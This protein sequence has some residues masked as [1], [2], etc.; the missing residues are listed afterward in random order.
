MLPKP[1]LALLAAALSLPMA[2]CATSSVQPPKGC[3]GH[4]RRP[5][6][7]NG[8]VLSAK[9]TAL[10]AAPAQASPQLPRDAGSICR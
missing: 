8:S 4:H 5:A 10:A 6:N 7:P 9:N 2:A 1:C 3:D